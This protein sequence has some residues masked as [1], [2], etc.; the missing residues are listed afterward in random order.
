MQ[1]SVLTPKTQI[2]EMWT[3][4]PFALD[5]KVYLFNITN[6]DEITKG[7]KPIVQEVGPYF[8]E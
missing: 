4:I 2:R 7:G 8:F 1:Q 5:F 6:P 3:N